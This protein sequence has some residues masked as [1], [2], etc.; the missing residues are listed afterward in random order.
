MML[1]VGMSSCILVQG[2]EIAPPNSFTTPLRPP[3]CASPLRGVKVLEAKGTSSASDVYSLGMVAWEVL[4]RE[5]PWARETLPR[6][7]YVRVVFK[8]DRPPIPVGT[9][10]DIADMIRSCWACAP[11]NRSTSGELLKHMSRSESRI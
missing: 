1:V 5:V 6:D 2:F 8:G 10:A 9:P 11:E 3:S 4:S 7:I